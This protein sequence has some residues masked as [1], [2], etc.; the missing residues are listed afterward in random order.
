[1]FFW[2][3]DKKQQKGGAADALAPVFT[4]VLFFPPRCAVRNC[5]KSENLSRYNFMSFFH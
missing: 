2:I 5:G 1:M 4:R 3:L